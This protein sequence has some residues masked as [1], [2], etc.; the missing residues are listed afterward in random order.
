VTARFCDAAQFQELIKSQRLPLRLSGV[1][2][3]RVA[4]FEVF[5]IV[6]HN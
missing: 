3:S 2:G 5:G 1:F 4:S 6:I